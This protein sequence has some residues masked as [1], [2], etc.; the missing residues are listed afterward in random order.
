VSSDQYDLILALNEVAVRLGWRPFQADTSS[1]KASVTYLTEKEYAKRHF[2]P[3][4]K[5]VQE[6]GEGA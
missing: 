3:K 2:K 6:P 4:V 1:T 5:Q